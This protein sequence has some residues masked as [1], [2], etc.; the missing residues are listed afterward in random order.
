MRDMSLPPWN[1]LGVS[2]LDNWIYVDMASL[3]HIIAFLQ[4][5]QIDLLY[6]FLIESNLPKKYISNWMGKVEL[7]RIGV[8][9]N[10]QTAYKLHFTLWYN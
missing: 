8:D 2:N 6:L 10:C 1:K 5:Q 9:G 3:K 4:F 7:E